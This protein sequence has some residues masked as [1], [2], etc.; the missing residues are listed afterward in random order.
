MMREGRL[1]YRLGL[2]SIISGI[3]VGIVVSLFRVAIPLL[4]G[5]VEHLL[6]W[7]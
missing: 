7:G 5:M 2:L 1:N 6:N 4:M 3:L